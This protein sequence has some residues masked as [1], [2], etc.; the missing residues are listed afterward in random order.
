MVSLQFPYIFDG[1]PKAY[2]ILI[3]TLAIIK[4]LD[5]NKLH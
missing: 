1:L 4:G 3:N 5:K 2:Y